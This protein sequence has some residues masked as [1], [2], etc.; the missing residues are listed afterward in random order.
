MIAALRLGIVAAG[1]FALLPVPALAD[2]TARYSVDGD[3][4]VVEVDSGGDFRAGIDGKATVFRRGGTDYLMLQGKPGGEAMIAELDAF[5]KLMEA[6]K[7]PPREEKPPVFSLAEQGPAEIG[8]RKGTRW[9]MSIDRPGAKGLEAVMSPD[10]ALR[11]LGDVF[12]RV[13]ASGVKFMT[14]MLGE[15]GN[16][17]PVATILFAKGT[18]LQLTGPVPVTLESID[19]AEIDPKRFELPGRVVDPATMMQALSQRHRDGGDVE[20]EIAP[21][22]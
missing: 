20:V 7:A 6:A 18:P 21:T 13:V 15:T 19:T 4:I 16:F 2:I 5:L 22:P 10:P 11:P 9:L 8:G 17:A 12:R 1:A 3:V 14:P